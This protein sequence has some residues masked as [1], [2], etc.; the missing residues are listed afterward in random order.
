MPTTFLPDVNHP[1][2]GREA[3]RKLLLS[4]LGRKSNI[5]LSKPRRAA[6][7]K[8]SIFGTQLAIYP[9]RQ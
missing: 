7:K 1:T 8:I 6:H 4:Q 5:F 3:T 9:Y 2:L